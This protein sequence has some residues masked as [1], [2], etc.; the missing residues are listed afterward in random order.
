MCVEL[1][2]YAT[3]EDL[4]GNAAQLSLEQETYQISCIE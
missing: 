1:D 4:K 2:T 3:I